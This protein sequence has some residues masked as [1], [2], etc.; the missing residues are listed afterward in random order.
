VSDLGYVDIR[1]IL[2]KLSDLDRDLVLV[3][4]QAVNFWAF[5][6]EGRVP[7]LA[8][9][10]PFASRDVDFCGDRRTVR[11]CAQRLGGRARVSTLDDA[12]PN[13]GTVV[14]VDAKGVQ[15]SLDILS[16]PFGLAASEVRD[17]AIAVDILDDAGKTTGVRFHVMHPVLSLESRVHNVAGLADAYDTARGRTQLRA[18][19]VCAYEFM[20]DVLDGGFEFH[21]PQRTVLK[22]N[23][24]IFRFCMHDRDARELHRR[25]PEIDPARGI[26]DDRR[27]PKA[28]RE[29]RLVQMRDLLATRDPD[30][31]L[32]HEVGPPR[33]RGR[34]GGPER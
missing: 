11:Q 32:T 24:R 27:L 4:G 1:P 21:D 6:Y 33:D 8:R 26:L 19:V 10:G 31:T 3:G 28:F 16:A 29:K 13:S 25:H 2:A 5:V 18:S 17:T 22:L 7:A 14:F 9:A 12:T 15:R 30:P 20:K 23:E 34:G